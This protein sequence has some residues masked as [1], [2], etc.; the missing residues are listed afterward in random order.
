MTRY[1]I[2][3]SYDGTNYCGWQI[4][5]NALTVQEVL[6]NAISTILR[7]EIEVIAAGRTDSGVHAKEMIG[8]FDCKKTIEDI[9]HLISKLNSF[10]PKD[11]AVHKIQEVTNEAHARF[12]ADSRMYEYHLITGKNVFLEKYAMRINF[13]LDFE[14][15]NKACEHLFDYK[16]FTSFSK[17]HTDVKTN[18]C[19]IKYAKWEKHSDRWIFRIEADRFLRNMVRAI[20]GT[21]IDVGKGKISIQQFQKIIEAKNRCKAGISVPAKGLYLV[22]VSYPKNI[23]P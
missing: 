22:K 6:C 7:S 2:T 13:D 15:M 1:F 11:I 5:P 16:D 18:N 10:L 12:D 14:Q 21:L 9:Q 3:F 20:V 19:E 4:Q 8:H 17:L 23:L